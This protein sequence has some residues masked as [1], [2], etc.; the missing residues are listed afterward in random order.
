MLKLPVDILF[1][2]FL[3]GMG[4]DEDDTGLLDVILDALQRI[5]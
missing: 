4:N 2:N 1:C 3:P 5:Q